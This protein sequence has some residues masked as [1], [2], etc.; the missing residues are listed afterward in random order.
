MR[1]LLLS[2]SNIVDQIE[3]LTGRINQQ[4]EK[5]DGVV[6]YLQRYVKEQKTDRNKVGYKN[7]IKSPC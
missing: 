6:R 3:K 4:D 2:E 5:L 7:E 1:D